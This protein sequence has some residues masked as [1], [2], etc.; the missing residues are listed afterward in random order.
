MRYIEM[1]K[2]RNNNRITWSVG[3]LGIFGVTVFM[4][5]TFPKLSDRHASLVVTVLRP[6]DWGVGPVYLDSNVG[7]EHGYQYGVIQVM[8]DHISRYRAPMGE[9]SRH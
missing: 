6:S 3:G 9:R 2:I 1:K 8:T 5:T 7:S 4:W